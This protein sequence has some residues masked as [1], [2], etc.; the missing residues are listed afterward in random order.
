MT[1]L[2]RGRARGLS[3][4]YKSPWKSNLF[5]RQWASI[6][7]PLLATGDISRRVALMYIEFA[8]VAA[9]GDV[10]PV[11]TYDREDSSALNYYLGLASSPSNDYVR[12]PMIAATISSTD[13]SIWP[14][15]NHISFFAMT[16]GSVGEHG[17]ELSEAANSVVIGGA[18]VAQVAPS[19]PSQDLVLNR[20]YFN[21]A[22][23]MAKLA[24]GQLGVEWDI[25]LE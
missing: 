19:D 3:G 16:Q 18:L 17:K 13:V 12:V 4:L 21:P 24:T 15:G 5:M 25:T 23:Q 22:D 11:P 6:V 10:A 7:A 20:F 2:I 9:P 14:L 8:N 1:M